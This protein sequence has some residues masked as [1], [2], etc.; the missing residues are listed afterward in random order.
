M[1]TEMRQRRARY[2]SVTFLAMF[3]LGGLH[4]SPSAGAAWPGKNGAIVFQASSPGEVDEGSRGLGIWSGR[5]GDTR[6]DLRQLTTLSTDSSPQASP[7]GRRIVFL[8]T[9]SPVIPGKLSTA[10]IY[11]MDSGGAGLSQVTDGSS[12]DSEPAFSASGSRIYFTRVVPG[13]GTNIFTI[14]LNGS[15]VRRITAGPSTDRATA[16]SPS[17]R[18]IAFERSAAAGARKRYSH[19][20]VASPT[21]R[22]LRDLTPWLGPQ[23]AAADP[24]FSPD[25][26]RIAFVAN[27][28][29][30]S[31]RI[32]GS[33][34]RTLVRP[35]R[36][37][38]L[39]ANPT[40]SPDGRFLLFSEFSPSGKSSLRRVDLSK[41]RLIAN[42]LRQPHVAIGS[43]A[44][45]PSR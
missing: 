5:V 24:D 16:A 1:I 28:R 31:I 9:T 40:Y 23:E 21:G 4:M 6:E 34:G 15:G 14:G 37:G 18:L 11:T 38:Y 19:L 32:N 27:D 35:A 17:G 33:A 13:E 20:F 39:Y 12:V 41:R 30:M 43:A 44:W 10:A 36:D 25:G 8:R 26:R 29:L 45:A 2:L 7:D 42:P 3:A 22:R